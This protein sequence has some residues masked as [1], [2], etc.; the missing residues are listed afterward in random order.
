MYC[1]NLITELEGQADLVVVAD[2]RGS[3]VCNWAG[4]RVPLIFR[5]EKSSNLKW[6]PLSGVRGE[7]FF[8]QPRREVVETV[9]EM[10]SPADV[11]GD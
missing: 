1:S 9:H 5:A 4:F 8:T 3:T 11:F 2:G 7:P 10:I 6:Q